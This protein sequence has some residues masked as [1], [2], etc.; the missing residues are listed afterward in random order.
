MNICRF[1]RHLQL[2][3]NAFKSDNHLRM[4]CSVTTALPFVIPSASRCTRFGCR[5]K[6]LSYHLRSGRLLNGVSFWSSLMGNRT[7]PDQYTTLPTDSFHCYWAPYLDPF[8][9][10]DLPLLVRGFGPEYFRLAPHKLM[11]FALV[12]CTAWHN[13]FLMY[14][15]F[16]F[17]ILW[18]FWR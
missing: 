8:F 9:W 13:A 6:I 2:V 3:R 4:D 17:L 10:D 5:R 7:S 1:H 14:W 11:V 12:S 15:M 16:S 18:P